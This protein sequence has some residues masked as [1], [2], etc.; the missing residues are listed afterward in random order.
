MERGA[1]LDESGTYHYELTRR[2]GGG[3]ELV[4]I[5]L[6]PSVADAE[7]DDPTVKRVVRFSNDWGFEAARVV[8]LFALRSTDRGRF[9]FIQIR[10]QTQT[11]TSCAVPSDNASGRWRHGGPSRGKSP[12]VRRPICGS[13]IAPVM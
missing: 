5:L 10:S 3:D 2:W 6:N 4:W 8:N 9:G 1:T 12:L 7:V 11:S 13:P